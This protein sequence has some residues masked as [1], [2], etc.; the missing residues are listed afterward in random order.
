MEN[1]NLSEEV[2]KEIVREKVHKMRRF[3]T[4]IFIYLIVLLIYISKTY[5]R[6][7]FNFIP[8]RYI[9][10]TVIWIWTFII[11]VKGFK[12]FVKEK[13]LGAKWEQKKINEL[14]EKEKRANTKWN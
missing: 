7:P 14:I 2:L 9:N 13:F 12:F 4:H 1:Y 6:A 8:L 5:Y 10:E 11:A 3:Y